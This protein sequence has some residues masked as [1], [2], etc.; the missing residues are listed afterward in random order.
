MLIS[1]YITYSSKKKNIFNF[2]KS[3]SFLIN[4]IPIVLLV[5]SHMEMLP[6]NITCL[7]KEIKFLM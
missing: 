3:K 4:S 7:I 1:L 5:R 2:D 6:L